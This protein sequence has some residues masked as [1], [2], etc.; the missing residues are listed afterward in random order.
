MADDGWDCFGEADDGRPP[1]IICLP[2]STALAASA[3]AV[4]LFD[5]VNV[6]APPPMP[7]LA[8][9]GSGSVSIWPDSPPVYTGPIRL[10]ADGG[11]GGGRGFVAERDVHPGELLLLEEPRLDWAEGHEPLLML[12]AVLQCTG[13]AQL[14]C[15]MSQLHPTALTHA[16]RETWEATHADAVTQLLPRLRALKGELSEHAARTELLRLCLALQFNGFSAG[17]FLHQAIF[18]HARAA[19]A[20][21]DKAGLRDGAGRVVSGVRATRA[22][23]AGATL[24]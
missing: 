1:K 15:A 16:L 23:R 12:R 18:N 20:N 9:Q 10:V 4:S 24:A 5:G 2:S 19:D 6:P 22:I 7:D 21:C 17:L 13:A 14:L 11:V 3:A 8:V